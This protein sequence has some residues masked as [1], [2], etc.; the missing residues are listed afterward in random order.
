MAGD[1][2][3]RT[4]MIKEIRR[5]AEQILTDY[6][7]I[8]AYLYGSF[9]RNS[10]SEDSDVDLAVYFKDYKLKKLLEVGRRLEDNLNI[11]RELDVR[12]L[13]KG[14]PRFR[15]RVIQEGKAIYE[16]SPEERADVETKIDHEY[17]DNLRYVQQQRRARR[18][19]TTHG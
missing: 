6:D 14:T 4:E 17:H 1:R 15:F 18:R 13:N 7:I 5:A 3:E 8:V 9:A 19:V 10:F 2:D 11:T 16:T 12:A